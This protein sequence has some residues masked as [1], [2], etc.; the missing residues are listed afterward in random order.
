M[1]GTR[2][3]EHQ[4]LAI[5]AGAGNTPFF[6]KTRIPAFGLIIQIEPIQPTV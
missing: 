5:T 1:T 4:H 2:T 6:Q 3:S